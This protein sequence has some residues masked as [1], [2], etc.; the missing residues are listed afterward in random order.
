LKKTAFN[1]YH[2][3]FDIQAIAIKSANQRK[4]FQTVKSQSKK[5]S[6]Q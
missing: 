2:N 5:Q 3:C 6:I 4:L 1:E